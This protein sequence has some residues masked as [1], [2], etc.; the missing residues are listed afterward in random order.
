MKLMLRLILLAMIGGG[1]AYAQPPGGDSRLI[2]RPSAHEGFART[3]TDMACHDTRMGEFICYKEIDGVVLTVRAA[4]LDRSM[5][6]SASSRF[7]RQCG[8]GDALR[9]K[10]C[11]MKATFQ[12]GK[13]S[14]DTLRLVA[15]G[16][17]TKRVV[18]E[19]QE[20]L[21]VPVR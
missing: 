19:S 13:T 5:S 9:L 15:G 6:A 3:V 14:A 21:L 18:I 10:S 17:M 2:A 16:P 7:R 20:L 4:E 8:G 1:A 12:V 11:V